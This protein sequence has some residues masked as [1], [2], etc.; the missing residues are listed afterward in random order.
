MRIAAEYIWIDGT[1]N[2]PRLRSKTK[3]IDMP[4]L[5]GHMSPSLMDFPEW[6]FDGSSTKQAEGEDSDCVLKPVTFV[7]S[8]FEGESALVLCE[9][10]SADGTPHPTNT[11]AKLREILTAGANDLE[12]W[13]GIEQEYFLWKDG[14]ALGWPETG[15]PAPQHPYYCGVGATR[16]AGRDIVITHR[17]ACLHAGLLYE[18]TNFEV[19]LGQAE[20]QIGTGTPLA[21]SDH[22]WL[23]RYILERV[24][25]EYDVD[26][27]WDPK[28]IVGDWNGSG[29]HT[30]VSTKWTRMPKNRAWVEEDLEHKDQSHGKEPTGM[31]AILAI[32]E[33]LSTRTDEHIAV[34]GYGIENRLT[35]KHETCSYKEFRFGVADRGASIRIPRHV[36]KN[37]HGYL[38]DR[39]PC[40]NADP[41][42]VITQILK[43]I[44]DIS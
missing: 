26:V 36:E 35:G 40:S 31:A 29:Q 1:P 42:A 11:R 25:E 18:G 27:N 15:E 21:V 2:A 6:G 14:R 33:K 12:P 24:A 34:Y 38:E 23:A 22:L 37:G 20:F 13:F 19:A 4:S 10:L 8:P 5:N 28:P 17:E 41:Y 9:V 7:S 16:V 3:M 44:C 39:R 32:C 30:N 43:T